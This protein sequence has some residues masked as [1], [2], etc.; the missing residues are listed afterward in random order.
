MICN[1]TYRRCEP[2][3]PLNIVCLTPVNSWKY[4][5]GSVVALC[6]D[7]QD[8]NGNHVYDI[9]DYNT[10]EKLYVS[11]NAALDGSSD[12][13]ETTV[14]PDNSQCYYKVSFRV[15]EVGEH[16]LTLNAELSDM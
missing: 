11:F 1:E 5:Q 13:V 15:S 3:G 14:N 10:G 16:E 7:V 8:R 12:N 4:R 9:T 2:P 6:F